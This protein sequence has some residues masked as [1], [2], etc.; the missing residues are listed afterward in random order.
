MPTKP[1]KPCSHP[2]C[3][4]LTI[5]PFCIKHEGQHKQ[6]RSNWSKQSPKERGYGWTWTKIRK[7]VM[8]R[9][10]GI[11]QVCLANNIIKEATEVDHI[12]PKTQGGTDEDHNLQAI[13]KSCHQDKTAIESA[14]SDNRVSYYPEWLPKPRIPVTII[15][16]PPGSGKSTYAKKNAG[17]NDLVIDVDEIAA[18]ITGKPIYQANQEEMSQAI[19]ARN[20]MLADL[21]DSSYN[22]CWFIT[23]GKYESKREWWKKKLNAELI[24]LETDKRVCM[25][26]VK[27]DDRRPAEAKKMAIEA[28]L[29]WE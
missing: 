1:L 13:C 23:T 6:E 12:V 17:K 27:A 16:G 2:G 11:C 20:K 4:V 3:G 29:G 7:L 5:E 22:K 26:R 25:A 21:A 15:A 8:L 10:G 9:D 28:I 14:T 24:V 18:K 19:R